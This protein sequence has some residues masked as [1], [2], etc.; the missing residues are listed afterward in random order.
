MHVPASSVAISGLNELSH[1]NTF[2]LH[3]SPLSTQLRYRQFCL[4]SRISLQLWRGHMQSPDCKTVFTRKIS[5][6]SDTCMPSLRWFGDATLW[7]FPHK[8]GPHSPGTNS[9]METTLLLLTFASGRETYQ[10]R[11][12][13]KNDASTRHPTSNKACVVTS[14]LRCWLMGWEVNLGLQGK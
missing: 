1:S 14:S 11:R 12:V 6:P 5:G 7:S 3:P 13:R 10:L 9:D 8:H 2:T 4:R